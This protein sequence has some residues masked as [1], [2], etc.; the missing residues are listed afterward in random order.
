MADSLGHFLVTF[1]ITCTSAIIFVIG[2]LERSRDVVAIVQSVSNVNNK[3][4][5]R[6]SSNNNTSNRAT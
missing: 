4:N 6:K 2:F 1:S 3:S 5:S